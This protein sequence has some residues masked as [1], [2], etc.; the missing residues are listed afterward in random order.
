[1]LLAI[2]QPLHFVAFVVLQNTYLDVAVPG[3]GDRFRCGW[4]ELPRSSSRVMRSSRQ[5]SDQSTLPVVHCAAVASSIR[6]VDL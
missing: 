3:H 2:A 4:A 6:H 5:P 1:M